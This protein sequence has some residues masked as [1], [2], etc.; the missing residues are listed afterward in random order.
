MS[1]MTTCWIV[2]ALFLKETA[3]HVIPCFLI[4]LIPV[5]K[6]CGLDFGF[7]HLS[8]NFSVALDLPIKSVKQDTWKPF[9]ENEK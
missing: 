6:I 4:F 8:F 5:A 2:Q 9:T 3:Q 7:T 1:V